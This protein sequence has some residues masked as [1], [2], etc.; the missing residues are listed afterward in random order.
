MKKR[1]LALI[2]ALV[3]AAG[4]FTAPEAAY[5][6]NEET[7]EQMSKVLLI[8]KNKLEIGDEYTEFSYKYGSGESWYFNWSTAEGDKW[9][10]GSCD[11][12]GRIISVYAYGNERNRKIPDRTSDEVLADAQKLI[13]RV[14]PETNGH[15]VLKS[16]YCQYYNSAY[17]Y[18]FS[19]IENGIEMPDNA[20]VL[21]VDYNTGELV[22]LEV[23]WNYTAKIPSADKLIGADAAKK[24]IGQKVEM[25]LQYRQGWDEDGNEKIFLAYIPL[26]TYIAVDARSGEIYTERNY[27]NSSSKTAAEAANDMADE[28]VTNGSG[29]RAT[30]SEAELKKIAELENL[31]SSDDAVKIIRN[32]KYLLVDEN[33][34]TVSASLNENNGKYFWNITM[35]DNRPVNYEEDD[36]FRSYA[37]ATVNAADG[38]LISY[39]A[40]IKGYYYYSQQEIDS[41]KF[42]YSKKDCRNIFE[43]FVKSEES[44]KF[45]SC[46]FTSQS[47]TMGWTDNYGRDN[48]MAYS[49]S[50]T[51]YY[52]DIPFYSNGISGSVDR[53]TGKVYS[54]RSSWSDAEMPSSKGVIGAEKAFDAY[55][56][57]EGYD[58]IYELY[59][60]N[61]QSDSIYGYESEQK[62]RLVYRTAI[63]P[64][65]VDAKTGKQLS[66]SGQEYE[67]VRTDYEYDD[68]AG[69]TYEKA[70][71]IL[72][73][74]GAG[75]PGG[76]FKPDQAITQEEFATLSSKMSMFDSV[77]KFEKKDKKLTRQLAAKE[78]I[79]L[80]GLEKIAELDIYKL[81]YSDAS[82]VSKSCKGYV[83]LAS[84][85]ELFGKK[86]KKFNPKSALTRGEAAQLLLNTLNVVISY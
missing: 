57:Y 40:S 39:S 35:R 75:L 22:N 17:R 46:K 85:L 14:I 84:G 58:L 64:A 6:A 54:Y 74:L 30:L 21:S 79:S 36:T 10:N 4:S 13:E 78:V 9:I 67:N 34:T 19:R 3:L 18:V 47:E 26:T 68:I 7:Q 43:K 1:V 49:L 60:E 12:E 82:K 50:Y 28:E 86:T 77:E 44:E 66:W 38:K 33:A 5:A 24:K 20:V 80:L 69:T 76:S 48:F 11:E 55:M 32:N 81:S 51:R 41:I 27:W 37:Y 72:A 23:T 8:V 53:V 73:D 25:E 61:T 83:A 42:N 45:A 70:I 56:S 52:E 31:I 63:S 71:R 59:T 16:R 2:L 15:L 29:F 62:V 65:I